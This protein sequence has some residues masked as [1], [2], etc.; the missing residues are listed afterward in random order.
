M[1]FISILIDKIFEFQF[2][3]SSSHNI[4]TVV[5]TECTISAL[6]LESICRMYKPFFKRSRF[7]PHIINCQEFWFF[8]FIIVFLG[9][10][11]LHQRIDLTYDVTK[12]TYCKFVC[13]VHKFKGIQE[14]FQIKST[15]ALT[16]VI[17]Y[18]LKRFMYFYPD[19]HFL[20]ILHDLPKKALF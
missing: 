9:F 6:I 2:V 5:L 17:I 1:I 11:F 14:I 15:S 10:F 16:T 7:K 20:H 4:M 19:S 13:Q 12:L 8:F 3:L 18:L